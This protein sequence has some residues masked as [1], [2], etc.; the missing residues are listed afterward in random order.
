MLQQDDDA[1]N[2]CYCSHLMHPHDVCRR[3]R[4]IVYNG[5]HILQL[6]LLNAACTTLQGLVF[7]GI[8]SSFG[9]KIAVMTNTAD[10]AYIQDV[11]QLKV[12]MGDSCD[13]EGMLAM[14]YERPT[15][16]LL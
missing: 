4:S 15:S 1:Q 14:G 8:S 3:Y 5:G 6:R 13:V 12:P 11:L 2:A 7:Q 16:N 9:Y 10:Y